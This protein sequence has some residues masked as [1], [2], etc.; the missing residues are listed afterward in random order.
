MSKS[1]KKKRKYRKE[2]YITERWSKKGTLSFQITIPVPGEDP[3]VK[4]ICSSDYASEK[5]ALDAACII[6]NEKIFDIKN[7]RLIRHAPT[8][9]EL[10]KQKFELFPCSVKT[11]KK[12]DI[13]YDMAI[14]D[15]EN[16]PIDKITAADIQKSVNKYA[17]THTH[18]YTAHTMSVWR[19]IFKAAQMNG[20]NV[21]D[22]TLMISIP[23]QK[24]VT[25]SRDVRISKDN[26]NKFLDALLKYHDYDDKG[27]YRSRSI[28]YMLQ[29]MYYTGMRNAEVFAL[30]RDAIDLEHDEIHITQAVG[31]NIT[32]QAVIIPTKTDKSTRVIPIAPGLHKILESL[33]EW[34]DHEYLISDYSG[35][36]YETD[37]VSNYIH[38]VSKE[39]NIPFNAYRLRHL[40]S[41][42]LISGKG[43]VRLAQDLLG[44][45]N[46]EMTIEYARSSEDKLK[47]AISS[48]S[49]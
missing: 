44:H 47:E 4:S 28:W 46:P 9:K 16:K 35:K 21:S 23:K 30:T 36:L 41:T 26:I 29:I 48:R 17:E 1:K 49:L 31:S 19:Q 11:K 8:I 7:N 33:M 27:R 32:D 5:M 37:W 15:L 24:T 10:Y 6:R 39:C 18:K 13:F 43:D 22:K 2:R 38:L 34:T 45:S 25:K 42:D 40:M 12:H 14:K 3:Y 20:I